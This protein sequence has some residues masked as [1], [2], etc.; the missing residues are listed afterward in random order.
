MTLRPREWEGVLSRFPGAKLNERADG[1]ALVYLPSAPLPAGWS[2]PLTTVWFVV[3][4]G[5]PA[6]QPD[7]FWV[8]EGVRLAGGAMPMNSGTQ[9]IGGTGP[10]GLWF[11]WHL[12]AWQPSRDGLGAFI[13]FI[14][15][16]LRHAR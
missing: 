2:E 4:I 11:S 16:R 1:S 6:A 8:D 9:P 13:R 14:E 12:P 3:P 7:C 5:Y 10:V 15:A